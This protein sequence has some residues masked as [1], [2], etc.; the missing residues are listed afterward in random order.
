MHH[1]SNK[2]LYSAH[3]CHNTNV[4]MCLNPKTIVLAQIKIIIYA[5][6]AYSTPPATSSFT[7]HSILLS[8][9]LR[10][11]SNYSTYAVHSS[12]YK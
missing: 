1:K 3:D 4:Q 5:V 9:I 12:V 6:A 2:M 10:A 11:V 7:I 8:F